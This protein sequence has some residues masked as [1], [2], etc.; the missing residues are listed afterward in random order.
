M[1]T[2]TP[3]SV[4]AADNLTA[5][6]SKPPSLDELVHALSSVLHIR[7]GA[8]IQYLRIS[9]LRKKNLDLLDAIALLLVV[10]DKTD[11]VAV[12]F[13]ESRTSIEFYFAK[14]YPCT[15]DI[16]EYVES[17]LEEIRNQTPEFV[18]NIMRKVATMCL[19]KI[20]N[21]IR[22]VSVE[23]A[24]SGVGLEML[25][26]D[27]SINNLGIWRSTGVPEGA[28]ANAFAK[29]YSGVESPL[30]AEKLN[31]P[32]KALL[33]L[34]FRFALR[35]NTSIEEL[36]GNRPGVLELLTL[37]YY[38]GRALNKDPILSNTA[39]ICRIQK[40][41]DYYGAVRTITRALRVRK[42]AIRF[43]EVS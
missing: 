38:I 42:K 3:T 20:R 9:N 21:R 23:L 30:K 6:G 22:K 36:R 26:D 17:F 8:P 28:T 25:S 33:A 13:L 35:M 14:N 7:E 39:L 32:D 27:E 29:A 16:I 24:N 10:E 43:I 12:S 2:Q 41:G 19:K 31:R 1:S 5:S 15:A 4:L 40:L 18:Q 37:S 34:Y 11:A